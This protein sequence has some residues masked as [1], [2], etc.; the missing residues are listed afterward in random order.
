[1]SWQIAL[2]MKKQRRQ[3]PTGPPE[4]NGAATLPSLKSPTWSRLIIHDRLNRI[5]SK[6]NEMCHIRHPEPD[7]NPFDNI[8]IKPHAVAQQ[9]K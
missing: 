5:V 7:P 4:G 3:W 9:H 8:P 2:H 1:M 6:D